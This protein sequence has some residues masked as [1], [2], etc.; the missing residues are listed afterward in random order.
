[1]KR[2]VVLIFALLLLFDLANDGCLGKASIVPPP[3]TAKASFTSPCLDSSDKAGFGDEL[4]RPDSPGPPC[5]NRNQP[6]A[7]GG[8]QTLRLIDSCHIAS[9]GAIPCNRLS[10][11]ARF[12][13]CPNFLTDP[14]HSG[15]TKSHGPA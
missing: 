7:L 1:M 14:T 13:V 15:I 2:L 12:F 9:S 6:I 10:L 11:R 3:S 8:Q 5:R 4:L